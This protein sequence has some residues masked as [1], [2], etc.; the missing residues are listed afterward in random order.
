MSIW[1]QVSATKT[2]FFKENLAGGQWSLPS[3]LLKSNVPS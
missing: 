2:R 3:L 1:R